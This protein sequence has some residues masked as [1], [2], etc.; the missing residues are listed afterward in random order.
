MLG[1]LLVCFWA[2][3][4]L[5][6]FQGTLGTA[7]SRRLRVLETLAIDGRHRAV[8]LG[9]DETEHLVLIGPTSTTLLESRPKAL[10][11]KEILP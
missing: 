5:R 7:R 11:A 10:A 4:R 9:Q 6:L 1:L 8:L 3:K 2:L